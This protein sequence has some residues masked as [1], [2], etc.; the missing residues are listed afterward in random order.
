MCIFTL[1]IY[2]K[3][4]GSFVSHEYRPREFILSVS[5]LQLDSCFLRYALA[6]C[7]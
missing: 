4:G 5:G 1:H 2:C 6:E 3:K 7:V